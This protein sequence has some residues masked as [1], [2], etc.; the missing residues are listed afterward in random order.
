MDFS[1]AIRLAFRHWNLFYEYPSSAF[2][3]SRFGLS[4]IFWIVLKLYFFK[5]IVEKRSSSKANFSV[6]LKIFPK[7]SLQSIR[8]MQHFQ[9]WLNEKVRLLKL[10]EAVLISIKYLQVY[11]NLLTLKRQIFICLD[12]QDSCQD[13]KLPFCMYFRFFTKMHL[14][15]KSQEAMIFL[16]FVAYYQSSSKKA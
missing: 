11:F 1:G 12:F 3:L 4:F 14:L 5:Q 7:L 6:V 10:M 13:W 2:T 9:N 8:I 15:W 16:K